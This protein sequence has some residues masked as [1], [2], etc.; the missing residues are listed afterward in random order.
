MNFCLIYLLAFFSS[1]YSLLAQTISYD[2]SRD[3]F[4]VFHEIKTDQMGLIVPW[5]SDD[6]GRSYDHVIDLVWNFW[7]TM[8]TDLNGL[9]Y[10]MNHQ[11]WRPSN[12]P[13][14]LGG[15]QLNMALSSW[16]LLYMYNGNERI[17]ENMKFLADYYLT[18]S[19][20][21][22]DAKWPDIPFP[23]N[24]LTYSGIYDG[25]MVIG[26]GYAQPDKAGSFGLELINMF[27]MTGKE[28]YLSA[29]I[30]IANTLSMHIIDGDEDNSP[31]PF[32]IN[33]F[34]GEVG[35]LVSNRGDRA[36]VGKSSYTTN[37]VGT[38]ELFKELIKMG[39]VNW[40]TYQT[41]FDKIITW[42]KKYPLGNNKWG[43]FFEDIPGW[44]DT[45][46]NAVTFA[47][48]M[49]L[50]PDLFPEWKFQVRSILD[51]VYTT[52]G[53][54]QWIEYGVVVVNEQTAYM[55]PGNSHTSRQAAA[56]LLYTSLTGD[57]TMY[58]NAIRQLNWATYMVDYDGKNCY[59]RDEV[60][61]TDGYGDYVR[62]YLRAMAVEPELAP[63][64]PNHILSSTSVVYQAG[65]AP[66][67][68]KRLAREIPDNELETV[69][70]FYKTFDTSSME[71]IRMNAKP[72]KIS[73]WNN[74]LYERKDLNE[75]GWTWEPMESGGLLKIRHDSGNA[76]KVFIE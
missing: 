66:D 48:F 31:L 75:E 70:I 50:N 30:A 33:V 73:V 45:Q 21:P 6:P 76:I 37:W 57:R 14:G 71:H 69:K 72:T 20:S 61:L 59:P 74:R 16:R 39:N 35:A 10:Y 11:V 19:L 58:E 60:W 36:I 53:N 40:E 51:W 17:K 47:R 2:Q 3:G 13:R 1:G 43:P 54:E 52:L 4:L 8:R 67:L 29:A 42:M 24:T 27:K 34:T 12:D 62:H 55:T 64:D 32:K 9:P 18:H 63:S 7:D 44:S 46:V 23:Y 49:M 22:V 26:Q 65:Y 38:L 25:D 56:E 41:A 68:N 15:D 28:N 5:Y